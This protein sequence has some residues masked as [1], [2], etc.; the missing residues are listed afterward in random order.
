[1]WPRAPGSYGPAP[2]RSRSCASEEVPVPRYGP[3]QAFVDRVARPPRQQLAGLLGA[4]ILLL[5][6]IGGFVQ[7]LWLLGG[8]HDAKDAPDQLKNRD[9]LLVGKI[10][11]LTLQIGPSCQLLREQHVGCRAVLHVK[12]V[13]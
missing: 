9:R 2:Q 8:P 5:D 4:Q 11:G 13:T 7:D 10:E 6:L 1:M 12:V 3:R